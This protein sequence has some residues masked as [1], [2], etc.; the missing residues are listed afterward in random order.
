MGIVHR[1]LKPE[2]ILICLDGYLKLTDFGFAKK[3]KD[4]TWTFC[5][6]PE[7]IAPEIIMSRGYNKSVD[8]WTLGVLIYEMAAGIPPFTN[9]DMTKIYTQISQGIFHIPS[10]FSKELTDLI[11]NLLQ[12]DITRRYGNLRFSLTNLFIYFSLL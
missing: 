11:T 2:N 8:W 6:T 10:F 5:G 12:T 3:I 7:Y 1:D 9:N 4:R